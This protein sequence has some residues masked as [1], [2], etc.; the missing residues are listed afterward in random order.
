MKEFIYLDKKLINSYLAQLDEGLLTK[1]VSGQGTTDTKQEATGSESSTSTKIGASLGITSEVIFNKKLTDKK[2]AVYSSMNSEL[3]ETALDDYS[4]DV[5]LEKLTEKEMLS[6][7]LNSD[8][9][10][11]QFIKIEDSV[12]AFNFEQLKS[13]MKLENLNMI[14]NQNEEYLNLEN[15]IL[16]L[17]K[18]KNG[19][20]SPEKQDKIKRKEKEL[21]EKDAFRNFNNI[22]K[23]SSYASILFPDTVLIRINK[24][25]CF[26][27]T[28][29]IRVN[30]PTLSMISETNRKAKILGVVSHKKTEDLAPKPNEKWDVE[31]I[32]SH[33]LATS[34]DIMVTN[35]FGVSIGDY[36]V[37][38][39]AIYFE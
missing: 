12:V 28:K 13:A 25:L 23:A 22:Q 14:M 18:N 3:I 36:Y 6:T 39:I 9:D 31:K 37:Q 34:I 10:D 30:A 19:K 11:G 16:T 21:V 38:P 32:Y 35:N 33:T 2:E 5:L 29:S 15:E 17:K 4:Y 20:K 8:W 26:C 7:D 27:D 24:I 1:M